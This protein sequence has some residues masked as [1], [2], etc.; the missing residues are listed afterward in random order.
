M[1]LEWCTVTVDPEG[2]ATAAYRWSGNDV[3]GHTQHDEDVSG[4]PDKDIR[5]CMAELIGA[6]G[7]DVDVIEVVRD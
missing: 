3:D 7:A 4:W 2:I 5:A 6:E 1:T